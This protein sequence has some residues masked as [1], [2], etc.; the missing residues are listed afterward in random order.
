MIGPYIPK[1]GKLIIY[2]EYSGVWHSAVVQNVQRSVPDT[3]F[4]LLDIIS[5][6]KRRDRQPRQ[7]DIGCT[8]IYE[9]DEKVLLGKMNKEEVKEYLQQNTLVGI[10]HEVDVVMANIEA[11]IENYQP[12]ENC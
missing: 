8:N 10:W 1:Q 9:V 4:L 6:D 2:S 12:K 5:T 11:L 7:I 3:D